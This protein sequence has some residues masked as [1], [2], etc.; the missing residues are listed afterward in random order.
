MPARAFTLIELLVVIA[1]V[2][3]LA[4]MLLPAVSAV[5]KAAQQSTCASNMRQ[6]GLAVQVYVSDRGEGLLPFSFYNPTGSG[7]FVP[8]EFGYPAANG[9]SWADAPVLGDFLGDE[10]IRYGGVP[11]SVTRTVVRCPA[12]A[13]VRLAGSAS[14][15]LNTGLCWYTG[16]AASMAQHRSSCG[17]ADSGA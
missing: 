13:G 14:I 16:T 4:G 11:S 10:R 1:I 3:I 12:D 9:A 5:K 2:A 17:R 15:A 6:I 7:S 8:V